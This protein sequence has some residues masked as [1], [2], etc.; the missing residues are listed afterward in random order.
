MSLRERIAGRIRAA[1]PI[2]FAE[3]MERALYD[4]PDGYYAGRAQRSGRG[5]DFYTSVDVGP[6]F[7]RLLGRQI[8]EL[9]SPLGVGG[10]GSRFDVVEAAA[11]NGRLARDILDA[12][13]A[14]T[15]DLYGAVRLTL[16]DRSAAAREV[17]TATLGPHAPRLAASQDALPPSFEGVLLANELLDA[18]PVHP[19][20]MTD[21]GLQEVFVDVAPNANPP[22]FV[23]R[24]GAPTA[25]V[26]AHVERFAIE[27][28]PGARGEVSPAVVAWVEA[29]ASALDRGFL[30]LLDYGHECR[31]LYSASHARGTVTSFQRHQAR[32]IDDDHSTPP[33]LDDPGG[34]DITA[35]VDL[36]AVQTAARDAGLEPVALADQTYVLLGLGAAELPEPEDTVA[37]IKQRL[38]LKTLLVPG[39]LGSTHKVM[40]FAKGVDT[41]GLALRDRAARLT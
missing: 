33:W 25:P 35:H 20:V 30:L 19:I 27:L 3:Y 5:G 16:V 14:D 18:L 41:D 2:P 9:A 28:A 17:H 15:P 23:E 21:A 31:E 7:G 29:A 11:G 37:A 24:L 6:V 8:A 22:R 36:T 32:T 10:P 4:E 38:A 1:G 13:Q 34:M 40:V 12:L 39:G 26:V